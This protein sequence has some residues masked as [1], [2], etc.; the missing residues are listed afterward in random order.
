MHSSFYFSNLFDLQIRLSL[1]YCFPGWL[2][3]CVCLPI[4]LQC[5][6]LNRLVHITILVFSRCSSILL[7][8]GYFICCPFKGCVVLPLSCWL[9]FIVEKWIGALDIAAIKCSLFLNYIIRSAWLPFQMHSFSL[10]WSLVFQMLHVLLPHK[11]YKN[12]EF[13]FIEYWMV[14]YLFFQFYKLW[15]LLVIIFILTSDLYQRN[16]SPE[17]ARG[18]AKALYDLYEVVTHELLSSDLRY[19]ILHMMQN[20]Y[21]MITLLN[22]YLFFSILMLQGAAWYME[23]FGKG[24]SKKWRETLF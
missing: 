24:K 8:F 15:W 18:A 23:H 7:L 16:E 1:L 9:S 22:L 13:D 17:I 19:M 20:L 4:S 14:V 6:F 11:A 10:Y 21:G 2:A 5:E 12:V 3:H